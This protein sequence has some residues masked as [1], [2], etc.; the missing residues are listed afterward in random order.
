[1]VIKRWTLSFRNRMPN[2]CNVRTE[3]APCGA[4][5]VTW[6]KFTAHTY[7]SKLHQIW[8]LWMFHLSLIRQRRP[9]VCVLHSVVFIGKWRFL[10]LTVRDHH[11]NVVRGFP[12]WHTDRNETGA[13]RVQNNKLHL[14]N[15]TVGLHI[16]CNVIPCRRHRF[17]WIHVHC[18]SDC[19]GRA[20]RNRYECCLN[21]HRMLEST[22]NLNTEKLGSLRF[23]PVSMDL[24]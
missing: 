16:Q 17:L 5:G 8:L 12:G 15:S 6:Q 21:S 18:L 1:M 22:I 11:R 2:T 13:T 9:L 20:L 24:L 14:Y 3:C 23:K 19:S 4:V 7:F 10:H